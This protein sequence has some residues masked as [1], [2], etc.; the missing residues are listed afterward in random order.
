MEPTWEWSNLSMPQ[1]NEE[2]AKATGFSDPVNFPFG[3]TTNN[4]RRRELYV[5]LLTT[6]ELLDNHLQ[7]WAW[8][9]DNGDDPVVAEVVK[10]NPWMREALS[11]VDRN[12][13]GDAG[14]TVFMEWRKNSAT[15]EYVTTPQRAD[16]LILDGKVTYVN[17]Q[18]RTYATAYIYLL[19]CLP[20]VSVDARSALNWNM[21]PQ[22]SVTLHRS[23]MNTELESR[24]AI[25]FEVVLKDGRTG[26]VGVNLFDKRIE[27]PREPETPESET[28]PT[29]GGTPPP[30]GPTPPPSGGG[31]DTDPDWYP[32]EGTVPPGTVTDPAN[33]PR[34]TP[35][36]VGTGEDG[37]SGGTVQPTTPPTAP[38]DT[39][40]GGGQAP[41]TQP[42]RDTSGAADG[43]QGTGVISGGEDV[44]PAP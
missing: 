3:G 17:E 5:S 16:A 20:I 23:G 31:K 7:G 25:W 39:G 36:N 27:F 19:D 13:A 34:T 42:P 43:G 37:G 10:A 40:N 8:M 18:Y 38:V 2:R 44:V 4:E 41:G 30:N 22:G 1:S 12:M 6:P 26:I 28:P 32:G 29:D 9:A 35:I 15:G 24:E 21:L 33:P 14:W 11:L